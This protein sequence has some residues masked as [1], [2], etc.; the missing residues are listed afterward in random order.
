VY[1]LFH[2]IG[3]QAKGKKRV[4]EERRFWDSLA[5]HTSIVADGEDSLTE[6]RWMIADEGSGGIQ[7]HAQE[8]EYG[9][10]L[11]IGRL[12]A[13]NSGAEELAASNVGYVVR[14]QRMGIDE[15]EIAIAR[16]REEIFPT[17]VEGQGARGQQSLPALLIRAAD[18]KW[19]LLCDNKHR[20]TIGDRVT[21][22]YEGRSQRHA[23][24]DAI[25]AQADFTVFELHE[26]A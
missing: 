8:G 3:S 17:V 18:G 1:R 22:V 23:L 20:F 16:L 13:Y 2:D 10:P 15:V 24:G 6:P 5:E 11:Y 21:V 19:Q 25:V 14:L 26:A 12:V 7:L 4:L 9:I